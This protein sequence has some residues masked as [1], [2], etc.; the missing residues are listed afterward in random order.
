VDLLWLKGKV[1]VEIDG[2]RHHGNSFAFVEDR[3]RDYEL[4]ISG[5]IVL[6]LSH[7]EVVSDVEIAVEKIRDVV[8]FR[9]SQQSIIK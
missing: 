2:Y 4:L 7:D 8:K 5:Y 1:V 9:H 6:R 3:H